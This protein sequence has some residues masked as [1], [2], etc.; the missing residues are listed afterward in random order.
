MDLHGLVVV[1]HQ[2]RR[3]HRDGVRID[4]DGLDGRLDRLA[5]RHDR[6]GL[7]RRRGQR[8]RDRRSH[9]RR[10][11]HVGIGQQRRVRGLVE[12]LGTDR[13]ELDLGRHRV[14]LR[15]RAGRGEAQQRGGDGGGEGR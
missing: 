13:V 14:V 8:G 10:I 3:R 7:V 5:G 12:G 1:E 15:V 2:L 9:E 11:G 4:D 6:L